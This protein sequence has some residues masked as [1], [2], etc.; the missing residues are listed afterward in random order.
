[1]KQLITILLILTLAVNLA[2]ARI[3]VRT[4]GPGWYS[5]NGSTFYSDGGI[6]WDDNGNHSRNYLAD[7][8]CFTVGDDGRVVGD[9][10]PRGVALHEKERLSLSQTGRDMVGEE[11]TRQTSTQTFWLETPG[12]PG[13]S[14]ATIR[15]RMA[16]AGVMNASATIKVNGEELGRIDL[17]GRN[18]SNHGVAKTGEWTF[19]AKGNGRV[20]VE[21]KYNVGDANGYLDWIEI[22]YNDQ[23][24]K[25]DPEDVHEAQPVGDFDLSR[26]HTMGGA[27]IVIV[28][29]ADFA[30]AAERLGRL[31]QAYDGMTY[32]VVTQQEI[33]NEYSSGTPTIEAYRA[34]LTQMAEQG[35]RY[36]VMLGDGCFDNRALT[37]NTWPNRDINRLITYQSPES[38]SEAGSYCT[39]DYFGMAYD[40]RD[41]RYD[42]MNLAVGRITAYTTQQAE[43]YV[44]KVAAYIANNDLGEW[45]NRA[46]F[47]A[48]DGDNNE[49]ARGADSVANLTAEIY[50]PLL[51]RKLYFDS[52]KQESTSAGESYPVLKRE[53]DDYIRRGVLMINYMGH[54]G[55]ANLANEQIVSYTDL[56]SMRNNRLPVW[57]TG[58]CN[59]SRF[60]D[61]KDSGGEML[62]LNPDGGAIALVSTTRTV[63]SGQNMGFN[64]ELSRL[65]LKPGMTIGEATRRAKNIRAKRGDSNRLCFLVLGDPALKVNYA[66][67]RNVVCQTDAD[68]VGALDLVEL[69]GYVAMADSSKDEQFEG[70]VH[71]T[72]FD[73]E[74]N[75][76]TLCNDDP[77]GRPFEYRYRINPIYTGKVRVTA[78]RFETHFIVPKDIKYNYGRARIVMYAWDEE[79]LIEGN[80]SSESLVIGGASADAVADTLG[81]DLTLTLNT[82]LEQP[83][84][85]TGSE[86]LLIA[87]MSDEYGINTVGSGIGHDI[88]MWVDDEVEG[89][90]LNNYYESDLGSYRSGRVEYRLSPLDPGLHHLRLRCWDMA[91]NSTTKSIEFSV[92]S[93]HDVS[94]LDVKVVPNPAAEYADIIIED[95]SPDKE[96]NL[97]VS[98]YDLSGREVWSKQLSRAM[99]E[100]GGN[101]VIRWDLS[102]AEAE[103]LYFARIRLGHSSVKTAKILV[104]KQ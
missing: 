37:I 29:V 74:E 10:V 57:I 86:P 62:L 21:I 81:P 95:D 44:D 59:F 68:T 53:L 8:K 89:T 22:N 50:K 55:Y 40:S 78:G 103:G 14:Q 43:N 93:R 64:L 91:N 87:R 73:K 27:D 35:T 56:V 101:I 51:T 76:R 17:N 97:S 48:D 85:Y 75:V 63:Y 104:Y 30:N 26:L 58:T 94:I 11:F 39:D 18:G 15:V 99:S 47:M 90:V 80:G 82:T 3:I 52:Y 16:H 65:L 31:H 92:D 24:T 49:H 72:V 83:S 41:I 20:G 19:T 88:V 12:L 98:I 4:N 13:G 5:Y 9:S 2:T 70:Y 46:I 84:Y 96:N 28:T 7:Y 79:R 60:D 77:N 6:T 23:R 36:L 32:E 100:T 69:R 25:I 1:M 66:H 33:F 45:K 71:I 61:V 34:F 102:G 67:D 38:Y 54:G 42:T